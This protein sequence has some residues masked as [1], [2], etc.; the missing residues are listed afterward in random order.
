MAKSNVFMKSA[1]EAK[2]GMNAVMAGDKPKER[3]EEP[4]HVTN[5]RIPESLWRKAQIHRI[6]TGESVR[7]LIV[8]LLK[9][10]LE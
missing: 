8:R 3:E 9:A 5:V 10:E 2:D 7:S 6:E 4:Q 1:K